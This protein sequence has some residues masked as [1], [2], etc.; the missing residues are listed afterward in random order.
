MEKPID[1]SEPTQ[2]NRRTIKGLFSFG[3]LSKYRQNSSNARL[4]K[5]KMYKLIFSLG[6]KT[7][8]GKVLASRQENGVSSVS[9]EVFLF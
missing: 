7:L 5:I 6:S 4:L 1:S 8:K 3:L 9:I 2:T